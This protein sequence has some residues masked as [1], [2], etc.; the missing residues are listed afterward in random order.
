MGLPGPHTTF[1][2]TNGAGRT[3]THAHK[4]SHNL[5]HTVHVDAQTS[6]WFQIHAV[7]ISANKFINAPKEIEKEKCMC[8][9]TA[10]CR[11]FSSPPLLFTLLHYLLAFLSFAGG[12]AP[13]ICHCVCVCVCMQ[14][15]IPLHTQT[16]VAFT[17]I[18]GLLSF[19]NYTIC[20][21]RPVTS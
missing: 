20:P 15:W 9:G 13:G 16:E 3:H 10:H 4:Y 17:S 5:S 14:K 8:C 19:T 21:C 18:T 1:Q 6:K 2:I 11:L 7:F 12:Q